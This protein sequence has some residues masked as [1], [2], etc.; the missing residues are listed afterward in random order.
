MAE[1]GLRRVRLTGGEPLVRKDLPE[2]V[3]ML[4]AVDGIDDIALSTNGVLLGEMADELREA[5]V[6]RV[7]LSLDS[8]RP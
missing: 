8:L 4:R 7:N 5:G 1:L 3:R 6:N 2:L